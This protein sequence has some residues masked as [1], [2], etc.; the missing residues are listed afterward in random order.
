MIKGGEKG[1]LIVLVEV[2]LPTAEWANDLGPEK[3]R[4]VYAFRI[5]SLSF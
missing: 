3:V 1:D 5:P 2:A 4:F